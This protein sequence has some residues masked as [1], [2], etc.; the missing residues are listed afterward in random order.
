QQVAEY[1]Y[2]AL[3]QRIVKLTPESITT[4]LYGPDGQLLGKRGQIY[5]PY[6]SFV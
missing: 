5:F 2:N 4:Y 6:S 1:R 3:G